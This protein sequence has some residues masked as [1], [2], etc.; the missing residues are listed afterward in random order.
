LS[1][2]ERKRVFG[3]ATPPGRY[4]ATVIHLLPEISHCYQ[5]KAEENRIWEIAVKVFKTTKDACSQAKRIVPFHSDYVHQIPGLPNDYVQKSLMAGIRRDQQKEERAFVIQEWVEGESLEYLLRT[6]WQTEPIDGE[7]VKSILSQLFGQ[8]IIPLWS[9]GIVWW[10]IRDGNYC[11]DCHTGRLKLIDLDSLAAYI[12]EIR[13]TPKIWTKR[14][15]GRMTALARLHTMTLR[16]LLAQGIRPKERFKRVCAEAWT[17]EVEPVL[18][19]L[20]KKTGQNEAVVSS[21]QRFFQILDD[22][23]CFV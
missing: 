14:D 7:Q 10:D 6:R 21:L 22:F 5:D 12:D 20:G 16:L 15:K 17:K 19:Q 2:E 4:A 1:S 3:K 18:S 13:L 23:H 11:Y 8:I 9:E